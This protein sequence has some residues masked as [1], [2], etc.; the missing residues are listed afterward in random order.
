[1][2]N[3]NPTLPVIML[4]VNGLST[5]IKR[6]ILAKCIWKKWPNYR[7][8]IKDTHLIQET[9]V[10]SKRMGKKIS[11]VSIIRDLVTKRDLEWLY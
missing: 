5:W 1:M 7:L 6:G 10:E 4:N 8:A 3:V 2:I 9:E 11:L